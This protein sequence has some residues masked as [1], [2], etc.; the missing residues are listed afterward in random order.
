MSKSH[1]DLVKKIAI[2]EQK[3]KDILNRKVDFNKNLPKCSLPKLEHKGMYL[4]FA[5]AYTQ[6]VDEYPQINSGEL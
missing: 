4:R 1:K 6:L 2:V 5:Y 3:D